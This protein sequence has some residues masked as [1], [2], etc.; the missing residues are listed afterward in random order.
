MH[1]WTNQLKYNT[2]Q[3]IKLF[4]S[5]KTVLQELVKLS[6]HGKCSG[7]ELADPPPSSSDLSLS[8]LPHTAYFLSFI[9]QMRHTDAQAVRER[10]ADLTMCPNW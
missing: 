10:H 3:A 8:L 1:D 5:F 2:T 4:Q 6:E 7:Q 9:D